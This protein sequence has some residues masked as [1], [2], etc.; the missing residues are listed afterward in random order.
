LAS[1]AVQHGSSAQAQG[2]QALL[3]ELQRREAAREHLIPFCQYVWPGFK[4]RLHRQLIAGALEMVERGEINRLLVFCPPQ[5]GKSTLVSQFFPAWYLGRN[6]EK[7]MILCSYN[8][9]L[10]MNHSLMARQNMR[11]DG[12]RRV[13]GDL[14][15]L[16]SPVELSTNAAAAKHWRLQYP[17]R[18]SL[19]TAGVGGGITGFGA[20]CVVSGTQIATESGIM[21]VE[22]LCAMERP[23]RV[24]AF[25]HDT[26]QAQ[27][28]A[29][30]ATKVSQTNELIDISTTGGRSLR[31]TANH[32]YYITGRGYR[33]AA[34]L[35]RGDKLVSQK[36]VD[37]PIVRQPQGQGKQ[38]LSGV[39]L[40]GEAQQGQ[41][42]VRCVRDEVRDR[43]WRT[44]EE[45]TP[46]LQPQLLLEQVRGNVLR[47][48]H[49]AY[50]PTLWQANALQ[51]EQGV[52]LERVSGSGTTTQT[53][54]D[55][56]VVQG[57][58]QKQFSNS[59]VLFNGLQEYGALSPYAWEGQ[60]ALQDWDELREVVYADATIDNGARRPQVRRMPDTREEAQGSSLWPTSTANELADSPYQRGSQGQY[61]RELGN[62][63]QY[64]SCDPSQVEEDTVSLVRHLRLEQVSVYDIQVE[65]CSNFFA[66]GILVHNCLI[67]D[68]PVKDAKEADSAIIREDHINWYKQSAHSRL[69]HGSDG[70]GAVIICQTRWADMDL[71]GYLLKQ[72]AEGGELWHVLRLP[73]MAEDPLTIEEWCKANFITPDRLLVAD[74]T[75]GI[76]A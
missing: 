60:P 73:A 76:A 4:P 68:D 56:C 10:A 13:F 39:L 48:Q 8:A 31:T 62:A 66:N 54:E 7:N 43:R 17:H 21:N 6:P 38:V 63:V 9:D 33:E 59:P 34:L 36:Q 2:K 18:G 12:Y 37:M 11:E 30:V 67:I 44:Q 47:A 29:V 64:V 51:P 25:N 42:D 46:R 26:N 28:C 52:L 61:S 58:I 23:P 71:S 53:D 16:D 32:R 27:L 24:W 20:N 14:S 69:S 45:D 22:Q 49:E 75:K 55:L 50:V 3:E 40:Q 74:T 5:A 65:G 19:K 70:E 15:G 72:Q 41:T 1:P 35:G 57:G